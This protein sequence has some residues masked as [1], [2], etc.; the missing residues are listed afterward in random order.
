VLAA[1][2][3]KLELVWYGYGIA[4]EVDFQETLGQLEKLGCR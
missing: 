4:Q 1:L 2:T 3:G